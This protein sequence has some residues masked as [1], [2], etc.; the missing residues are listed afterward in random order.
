[1]RLALAGEQPLKDLRSRWVYDVLD[2]CLMCKACKSECPANVDMAQLKAEF[3]E[4]HYQGRSRPLGHLLMG[5]IHLWY[6]LGAPLAP[7]VNRLQKFR[8]LR[9]LLERVAG[10]DRRRSLPELHRDHFRR[11]FARHS[12]EPSAGSR[13]RVILLDDCFTTFNDPG[14]GRAAVR[15]LESAGYAVELAGLVCCGRALISK[16]MVRSA[17]DLVQGQ[18]PALARRLADGTPLLGLEPSCLLTLVDEWPEL[19]PGADAERVAQAAVLADAWLA[20]QVR[21]GRT[22]LTLKPRHERVLVHGHCHQKA[23]V[24]MGG[25]AAALGLVPGLDVSIL[26]TGCCGMAGSFGFEKK[27]Y[28]LSTQVAELSLLP[29]LRKEPDGT[30]VAMGTSCRQQIRDLAGRTAWHPLEI[31]AEQLAHP[32]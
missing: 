14:V 12:P 7:L 10:I 22:E 20:G 19:V 4:L 2:L 25:T 6:R 13:G 1:L 27:H 23:L 31:L 24:G 18:L 9:W 32:K 16:G 5:N 11:W 3:L 8:P 30:V 21:A 15:L 28:G 29:A 26:E 17:R